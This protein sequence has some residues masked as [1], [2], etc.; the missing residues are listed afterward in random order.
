MANLTAMI[1]VLLLPIATLLSE[2]GAVFILFIDKLLRQPI[3]QPSSAAY[4]LSVRL[5]TYRNKQHKDSNGYCC[6]FYSKRRCKDHCD[7]IFTFCLRG[8][9]IRDDNVHNCPLQIGN[10]QFSF[11][12]DKINF[13]RNFIRTFYSYQSWPVSE[14]LLHGYVII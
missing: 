11:Y 13:P 4:V 5:Y 8:A 3:M 9:N 2:V 7:N 6:D 12:S 10:N 1:A 14:T